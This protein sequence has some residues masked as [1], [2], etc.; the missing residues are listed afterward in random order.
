MTQL[1]NRKNSI[2]TTCTL[3]ITVCVTA[4]YHSTT[5]NVLSLLKHVDAASHLNR[6]KRCVD[7]WLCQGL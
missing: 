6:K 1:I 2:I 7:P 5:P 3:Q 4:K